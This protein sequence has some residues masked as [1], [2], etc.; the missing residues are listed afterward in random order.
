MEQDSTFSFS[1]NEGCV[2]YELHEEQRLEGMCRVC[3]TSETVLIPVFDS[4]GQSKGIV[5]LINN[6][7][8]ILVRCMIIY[9]KDLQHY[10]SVPHILYSFR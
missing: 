4:D 3:A 6:H 5:D 8:P 7:L 1:L 2:E 10:C 9:C